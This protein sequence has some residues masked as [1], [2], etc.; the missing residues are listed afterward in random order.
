MRFVARRQ[1]AIVECAR[2]LCAAAT[3]PFDRQSHLPGVYHTPHAFADSAVAS[4]DN[5]E[6]VGL[7]R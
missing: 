7:D 5:H 2:A 6:Y 3:G 1:F 4:L